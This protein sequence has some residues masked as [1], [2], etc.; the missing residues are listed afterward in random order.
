MRNKTVMT[1]VR[2][3]DYDENGNGLMELDE[4]A[5]MVHAMQEIA[6]RV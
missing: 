2:S 6:Q 1:D 3:V 5:R 4:F